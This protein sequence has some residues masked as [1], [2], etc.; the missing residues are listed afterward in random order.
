MFYISQNEEYFSGSSFDT[1]EEAVSAGKSQWPGEKFFV[2][3]RSEYKPWNRDFIDDILDNEAGDVHDEC[4]G[5]A[6][7][8]WPPQLD[9]ASPEYKDANN[10]IAAI[11]KKLCGECSVFKIENCTT[12]EPGK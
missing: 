8:D 7:D 9:S 11:M 4:G 6:A 3:E 5:D 10:Q 1:E 12:I 2:G